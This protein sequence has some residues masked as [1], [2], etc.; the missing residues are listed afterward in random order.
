MPAGRPSSFLPEYAEQA[1]K[2][3]KLGATDKELANFFEV[4]EQTLN[5]WKTKYPEFLASLKAGKEHAD[6][7]VAERLFQR[8]TG[9]SH[10]EVHICTIQNEVV[11]TPITKHYPPDTTAAIF[12]LKNR[13][14]DNWRDKT[15]REVTVKVRTEE[16]SDDELYSVAS[17]GRDGTAQAKSSKKISP[18]LH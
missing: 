16:M 4:S 14:P 8:A 11:M 13:R 17:R 15:E 10:P 9:Y 18:E 6:A 1:E 5:T 2:L 12:W 3:C 7:T